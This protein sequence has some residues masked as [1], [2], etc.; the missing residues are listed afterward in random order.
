MRALKQRG[1]EMDDELWTRVR[2]AARHDGLSAGAWL[3]DV[4][5]AALRKGPAARE[6]RRSYEP[7]VIPD[8]LSRR[9]QLRVDKGET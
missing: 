6:I 1:F 2:V 3:R 8:D 9:E 7:M 4:S 5:E